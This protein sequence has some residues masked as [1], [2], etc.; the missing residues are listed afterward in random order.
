[1]STYPT[2]NDQPLLDPGELYPQS[3]EQG[4]PLDFWGHANSYHCP[5]GKE[6]GRAW[7]LL[8]RATLNGISE[9]A[10]LRLKFR[11]PQ[12]EITFPRLRFVRGTCMSA[13]PTASDV[14]AAYLLEL[15]DKRH[16]LAMTTVVKQYNIR[17]PAPPAVT[18]VELYHSESLNAGALWTWATL[19]SDLWALL[20][21]SLRG[22]TPSLPYTPDGTPEGFRFIGVSVW[23]AIHQVLEKIACTTVYDP[24]D[25]TISIVRATATQTNLTAEINDLVDRKLDD[26]SPLDADSAFVP[27]T[28]KVLFHKL[29]K[30]YG[31]DPITHRL[32]NWSMD[33]VY[34]VDKAS[35]VAGAVAGTHVALWDDR[36][37]LVN[38]AGTVQDTSGLNTRA[39]EVAANYV[40]AILKRQSHSHRLYGGAVT[41]ITTGSEVERIIWRD[42]G[43]EMGM[44][45]EIV[46]RPF[47]FSV[48]RGN[49]SVP[50]EHLATPDLSRASF[51]LYP[52]DVHL[53]EVVTP[54][55]DM[56]D[57]I[58]QDGSGLF[59]G[60][61]LRPDV[62]KNTDSELLYTYGEDCYIHIGQRF[63][64]STATEPR[65]LR[66]QRFL[67]RII[68]SKDVGGEVLPVY[69]QAQEIIVLIGKNLT[70]ETIV[71]GTEGEITIFHKEPPDEESAGYTLMAWNRTSTDWADDKW[72]GLVLINGWWYGLPWECP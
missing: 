31:S 47:S 11:S 53:V 61:V 14:A 9:T 43:D 70:G 17:C 30:H 23:D 41:E 56:G 64:G 72:G 8:T 58:P 1:M 51:P 60:K 52:R 5:R 67:A 21:A 45:T 13:G 54:S 16:W 3:R 71:A 50:S 18:G 26:L 19:V 40:N 57:L 33:P 65:L 35:G 32:G 49:A 12:G 22:S 29:Y 24:V 66:G 20:P 55:G 63:Y 46:N 2:L 44:L 36:P 38:A 28:I 59:P 62:D 42:Y 27:A 10:D 7:V 6:A 37:A 69:Q 34:V 39:T 4:L 25:D 15:A 68:G 48:G